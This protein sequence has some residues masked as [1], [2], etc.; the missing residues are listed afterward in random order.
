MLFIDNKLKLSCVVISSQFYLVSVY[1][2]VCSVFYYFVP[3]C[4]FRF[5]VYGLGQRSLTF[6]ASVIFKVHSSMI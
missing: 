4:V 6:F 1:V 2:S 5:V 3:G